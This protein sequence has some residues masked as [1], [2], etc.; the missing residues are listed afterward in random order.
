M[1]EE[2]LE[3]C[4]YYNE[5]TQ[6]VTPTPHLER[7]HARIPTAVISYGSQT[8]R[9]VVLSVEATANAGTCCHER[10]GKSDPWVGYNPLGHGTAP[11]ATR[12]QLSILPLSRVRAVLFKRPS[13]RE[14]QSRPG[15]ETRLYVDPATA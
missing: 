8:L 4:A 3:R 11:H 15:R 5:K 9:P 7:D 14:A 12:R 2:R 1:E 13:I 10:D 6:T